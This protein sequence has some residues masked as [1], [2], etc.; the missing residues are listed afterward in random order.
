MRRANHGFSGRSRVVMRLARQVG[1]IDETRRHLVSSAGL[2]HAVFQHGGEGAPVKGVQTLFLGQRAQPPRIFRNDAVAHGHFFVKFHAHFE[3]LA[4]VFFILVKQFVQGTIADENHF[5]VDVDRLRLLR[6]AAEGVKHFER[7][8]FQPI[9]VQGALQRAPHAD[10]RKRF[11]RI[12]DQKAAIGAEQRTSAQVHEVA[13]PAASRVVGALDGPEKIGVGGRGFKNDRRF[14]VVVVR[15][16]DVD[17]VNAERIALRSSLRFGQPVRSFFVVLAFA[18]ALLERIEIIEEMVANFFEVFRNTVAGIF[19]LELFDDAV[20]QHRGRFLLQVTQ[21]AGQFARERQRLPVHDGEFLAELLVLS[22]DVFGD[23]AFEL[24]LVH[25]FGD[26]LD[27]HHLAFE[28]GE[29]LRQRDG[30]H[31]HVAERK[32]FARDAARK[33]VHQ[34][35]FTHGETLDDASFLPLERL[36]FEHLR[37]PPAQKVD[38]CLHVLLEGVGLAARKRQQARAIR[39]FEIVDVAAVEGFFCGRMKFFDHVGDGSAATGAGQPA[40][41]NV[42]AGSRKLR[43]HLQSTQRALLSD[44]AFAE[45]RLRRGFEGDAR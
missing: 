18:F 24:S 6:A 22:L 45:F 25:H 11:Q 7:L 10:F 43:P 16:N 1:D 26:V 19:F 35:F 12:H 37:N 41:E 23:G 3:D 9:V 5:H 36:A 20:D 27:R 38:P 15:K 42:V 44:E 28:H 32:L 2:T 21:F 31:L 14:V 39:Q 33:I 30:A 40:H 17:A 34:F 8:N 4:K 29:N 13:G